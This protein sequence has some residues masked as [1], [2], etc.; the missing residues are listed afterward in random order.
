MPQ[1]E[2]G[3]AKPRSRFLGRFKKQKAEADVED[4]KRE[5]DDAPK[6]TFASQ[7]RATVLNSWINVLIFAA[8]AGSRFSLCC[9]F[10]VELEVL[11]TDWLSCALLRRC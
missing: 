4:L 11:E 10:V 7:L 3:V 6:F 9:G 1:G 8:P 5:D 2:N